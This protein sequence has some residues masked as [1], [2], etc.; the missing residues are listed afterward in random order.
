MV[1]FGGEG[2]G[3]NSGGGA[4]RMSM[5]AGK[6]PGSTGAMHMAA[7]PSRDICRDQEGEGDKQITANGA[8]RSVCGH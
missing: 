3:S 1:S 2:G 4:T 5:P 6:A 7:V 8:D